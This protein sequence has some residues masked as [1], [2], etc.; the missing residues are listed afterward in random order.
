MVNN[1]PS[2]FGNISQIWNMITDL[3]K[4]IEAHS[5]LLNAN[6]TLKQILEKLKK[7]PD[8]G[9]Q[10]EIGPKGDKP[11][12]VWSGTSLRFELPD[13]TWGS[14]VNLKGEK[15]V[16]G[17]DGEDGTSVKI[18]GSLADP[19][20]LPVSSDIGDGYIIDGD[21]WIW[22]GTEWQNVGQIRGPKGDTGGFAEYLHTQNGASD[23]WQIEHGL[24]KEPEVLC[25][26]SSG[27]D[28]EGEVVYE[29]VNIVGVHFGIPITGKA[30]VRA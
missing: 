15:G 29:S 18:L 27:N 3:R 1:S 26:D 5:A 14:Y 21:L 24:G 23:Y 22:T 10:G 4:R 7:I 8:I 6:V 17:I 25:I 2:R 9:P 16:D 28:I 30:W 19:A 13:G 12:H 11:D 20:D